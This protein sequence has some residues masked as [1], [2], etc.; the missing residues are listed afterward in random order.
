[1]SGTA[2]ALTVVPMR[3][4]AAAASNMTSTLRQLRAMSFRGLARMYSSA[5][6]LFV[7]RLRRA[8]SGAIVEGLSPRYTAITLIGLAGERD[9]D[10]TSVL[11]SDSQAEVLRSLVAALGIRNNLGDVALTMLAASLM[12]SDETGA[13]LDRLR[14]LDPAQREHPVV[15]VAWSLTALSAVDLPAAVQLR[16]RVAERLMSAFNDQSELFPHAIGSVSGARSHIACFADLIYPIQALAKYAAAS[17]DTRA[18]DIASRCARRVCALQGKAGQWWWHYDYRTGRIVEG[19]PV[20]AIHQDAMGPM[21]LHDLFD[22]GGADCRASINHGL[23]WLVSAPELRGGSLIDQG[24]DLIWR[25][26]ARHEPRKAVRYLQGAASRLHPGLRV[27]A[28]DAMFPVGA[29]DFEDRPY[30]LGWLLYAWP[31]SR[32]AAWATTHRPAVGA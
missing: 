26:V 2:Q 6:R 19:Y 5:D 25:K 16:E 15:E 13:L 27:P 11:G 1:M 22:A 32:V 31:E 10:V 4:V 9:A 8:A 29:I 12:E 23:E 14:N 17:G 28:V 20:Y 18:L 7:F 30:H 3:P 24:A 21:G